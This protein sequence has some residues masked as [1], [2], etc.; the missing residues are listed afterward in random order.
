MAVVEAA[1]EVAE[2]RARICLLGTVPILKRCDDNDDG[3][4]NDN[5]TVGDGTMA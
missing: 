3:S 4:D 5:S 1:T 2:A